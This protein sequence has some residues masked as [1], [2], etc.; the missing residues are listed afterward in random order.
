M[1]E[2]QFGIFVRYFVHFICG[3]IVRK[4][5]LQQ[6]RAL[7]TKVSRCFQMLGGWHCDSVVYDVFVIFLTK[8]KQFG[9]L[10]HLRKWRIEI[11]AILLKTWRLYLK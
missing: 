4:K 6:L 10:M 1:N 3:Y 2:G 9:D 11:K 5:D 7:F 8:E